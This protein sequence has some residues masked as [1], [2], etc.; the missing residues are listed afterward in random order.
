MGLAAGPQVLQAQS[1]CSGTQTSSA[2]P[3]TGNEGTVTV[4]AL[5]S[6]ADIAAIG[7]TVNSVA[8]WLSYDNGQTFQF[9]DS[10]G[11]WQSGAGAVDKNGDPL[12]PGVVAVIQPRGSDKAVPTHIK[13]TVDYAQLTNGGIAAA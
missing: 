10:V 5:M 2:Y 11:E 3:L 9:A 6:A 8:A 13:G 4:S 1:P 7:L 12:A